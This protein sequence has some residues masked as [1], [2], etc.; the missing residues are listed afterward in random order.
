[1]SR[2]ISSAPFLTG[3]SPAPGATTGAAIHAA[4]A[5]SDLGCTPLQLRALIPPAPRRPWQRPNLAAQTTA[6][7]RRRRWPVPAT[8]LRQKDTG[9]TTPGSASC[10]GCGARGW[11]PGDSVEERAWRRR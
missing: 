10:V 11:R 6:Q 5:R 7:R 1:M 4:G 2:N 3:R 9:K 8:R